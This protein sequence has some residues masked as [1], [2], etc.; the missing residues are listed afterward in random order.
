MKEDTIMKTLTRNNEFVV[1]HP[2]DDRPETKVDIAAL[3]PMP[4][5]RSVRWSLL[6]LRGYLLLMLVLVLY[7]V[8][9]LAGMVGRHVH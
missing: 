8:A 7:R 1:I 6:S 2:L 4:L 9:S 3:G 5:T